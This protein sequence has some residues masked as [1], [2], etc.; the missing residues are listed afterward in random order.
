MDDVF[1]IYVH[2]VLAELGWLLES[3]QRDYGPGNISRAPGGA[4]NGLMVRMNDKMERLKTLVYS[5]VE[6]NN[7]SIDDSLMDLANYCVIALMVRRGT[8]PK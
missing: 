6:P 8:W 4:L 1:G 5:T 7:E 2:D 3:K